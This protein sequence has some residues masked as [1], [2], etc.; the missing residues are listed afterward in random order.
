MPI[1]EY[2][3]SNCNH[4]FEEWQ[5]INDNPIKKCPKCKKNKVQRIISQTS[6]ALKGGGWYSDL[7]S[8]TRSKDVKKEESGSAASTSKSK[9]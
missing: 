4:Q 1:Y 9:S 2:E 7:Y 6:F 8:S 3:C 5:S